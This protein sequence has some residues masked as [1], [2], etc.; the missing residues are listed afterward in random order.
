MTVSTNYSSIDKLAAAR[1]LV[2]RLGCNPQ[3]GWWGGPDESEATANLTERIL[4]RTFNVALVQTACEAARRVHEQLAGSRSCHLFNLPDGLEQAVSRLIRQG[5]P[6][7]A[8][9]FKEPPAA[10]IADSPAE[11]P[12]RMGLTRDIATSADLNLLVYIYTSAAR[13][14]TKS[15]PIPYFAD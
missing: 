9:E 13:R 7:I 2:A 10:K 1:V 15:S 6:S 12:I 5:D 8:I 3:L 4:P 14:Q 11:G